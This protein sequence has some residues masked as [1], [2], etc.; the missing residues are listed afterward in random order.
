[1]L[2]RINKAH[3]AIW[4]DPNTIQIGLGPT[5]IQLENLTLSQHQIIDAIYSGVVSGQELAVDASL[6]AEQGTTTNLIS[7]LRTMIE[8]TPAKEID[9]FGPWQKISFAEIARASLDYEVNGEMVVAERWQRNIHIDQLDKT[10]WLVT[11]ALLASGIGTILTHDDGKVLNTDL[12]ELGFPKEKLQLSRFA[13]AQ[14]ELKNFALPQTEKPRLALLPVPPNKDSKVSFAVIVG[15]LALDPTRYARWN[16][17]DVPHLAIIFEMDAV[18]ISPII[19]PGKNGCLNCYQQTKI[20]EDF[21]WPIIAS[22][23]LDL[24]RMR[25]DSASLLASTGLA[26][27]LILKFLD[28]E[29]GFQLR[30]QADDMEY[31]YRINH[32]DGSVKRVRYEFHSECSCQKPG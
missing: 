14:A 3:P 28:L 31:G 16:N 7:R 20:D 11:R 10:G 6:K 8:K 9:I 18:E 24:P 21:S 25:D 19:R 4:R 29:A 30:D 15:H 32:S 27:K 2:H 5:N 12:G 22:Q 23:L 17:R 1:M 13:A 26:T